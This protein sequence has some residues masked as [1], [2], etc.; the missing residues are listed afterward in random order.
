MTQGGAGSGSVCPQCGSSAVVAIQ[1]VEHESCGAIKPAA[2]FQ[3][4]DGMHC[5]D[6]DVPI[7]EVTTISDESTGA[8]EDCKHIFK[9]DRDSSNGDASQRRE[10]T[11]VRKD[12]RSRLTATSPAPGRPLQVVVV[13][14]LI[15]LLV[16]AT[17]LAPITPSL[18]D[19]GTETRSEPIASPTETQPER[20]VSGTGTWMDYQSI[21]IFRNDDVQPNYRSETRRAVDRVFIEENVPV[22][23]G[24]VP[25]IDNEELP[26]EF[27][28]SLREQ[29][30]SHP[31]TFEYAL[32]GYSHEERTDFH[33]GSEFG[34]LPAER[35]ATLIREG[36]TA[37]QACLQQTPTTFIPPF[38]NYD[39]ATAAAL[40]D[41]EY[42]ALSGGTWFTEAYYN[43]TGP[44]ERNGIRHLPASRSFV[45]N[46]TTNEFYAQSRL[47]AA[48]D[49]A[50][51]DGEVYIQTLHYPTFTTE[52]RQDRLRGLINHMQSRDGVTF[53]TVGEFA[54]KYE[55]GE[56]KR[57]GDGWRVLE[58]ADD[59][60]SQPQIQTVEPGPRNVDQWGKT[61]A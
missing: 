37:L 19:R 11:V 57:T 33:G 7:N 50:Y 8:C 61:D 27:C 15:A 24:I 53:M 18:R 3:T 55:H 41:E 32:H 49:D 26:D 59:R 29:A 47:E 14:S 5:P 21:V 39:N 38:D 1:I 54:H 45:R 44:F 56:I 40:A 30:N 46:W 35:Q 17:M 20:S 34:G 51:R 36:T 58:S 31:D 12:I 23:L 28:R 9:I 43:E 13:M 4:E 52:S 60:M 2:E 42:A 25:A 6:C 10:P 22:T 16:L 48:F